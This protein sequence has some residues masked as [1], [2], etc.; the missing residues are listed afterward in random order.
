MLEVDGVSKRYGDVRALDGCT[1]T[2]AAK[3]IVGLLG[4]NLVA[5][6]CQDVVTMDHGRVVMAGPL[7][8]LQTA[9]GRHHIDIV[10]TA[11][12]ATGWLAGL[13]GVNLVSADDRHVR[14]AI[15]T[16]GEPGAVLRAARGAGRIVRFD[17]EPPSL[18]EMFRE[19][20]AS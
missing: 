4:P 10:F 17:F 2:A 20:V 15:G 7:E 19:A 12:P 11:P 14:L 1:F 5:H 8:E 16:G 6:L 3:R 13:A 18:E 9:T